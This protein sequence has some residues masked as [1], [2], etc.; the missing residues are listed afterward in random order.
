MQGGPG[1]RGENGGITSCRDA[2]SAEKQGKRREPTSLPPLG[3]VSAADQNGGS[4]V[5][6]S[7]PANGLTRRARAGFGAAAGPVSSA[8]EVAFELERLPASLS[9]FNVAVASKE[10]VTGFPS[11]S[12]P[13]K[14]ATERSARSSRA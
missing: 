9:T 4:R 12:T 2:E 7:G 8:L 14:S 1:Q 10:A 13:V 11:R 6:G 3:L 5:S